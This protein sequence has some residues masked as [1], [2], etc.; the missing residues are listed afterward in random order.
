MATRRPTGS[1]KRRRK[2]HRD[3]AAAWLRRPGAAEWH[4]AMNTI[5]AACAWND[6]FVQVVL[7]GPP[8]PTRN[9]QM[10][11]RC[12][13]RALPGAKR[14]F[15]ETH[16]TVDHGACRCRVYNL[17]ANV[18]LNLTS[19]SAESELFFDVHKNLV[20]AFLERTRLVN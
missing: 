13:V 20:L 18:A 15:R 5:L 8:S 19:S 9:E 12:L 17:L 10:L 16:R 14:N 4:D 6:A 7:R 3:G 1:V 11:K 2:Q